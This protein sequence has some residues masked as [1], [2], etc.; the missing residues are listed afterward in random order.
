MRCLELQKSKEKINQ[1]RVE[2]MKEIN[3]LIYTLEINFVNTSDIDSSIFVTF[4]DTGLKTKIVKVGD[5]CITEETIKGRVLSGR[6]DNL[7]GYCGYRYDY[8]NGENLININP[9]IPINTAIACI[10]EAKGKT[11][12][13]T[14]EL[15]FSSIV[16]N[17]F[18]V[19]ALN[20]GN[21]NIIKTVSAENEK[22]EHCSL[23]EIVDL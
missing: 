23:Q 13:L 12:F 5:V 7:E 15:V 3:N 21:L 4:H 8:Q 10:R 19:L 2:I 20:E 22:S 6:M 9:N 18:R 16:R 1:L 14:A 11:D 17:D